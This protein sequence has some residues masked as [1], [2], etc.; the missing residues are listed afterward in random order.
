MGFDFDTPWK[1]ADLPETLRSEMA[2]N[3]YVVMH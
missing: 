1:L 3:G 2:E